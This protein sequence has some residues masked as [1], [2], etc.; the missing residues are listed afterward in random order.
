VRGACSGLHAAF[1]AAA[2]RRFQNAFTTRR[3]IFPFA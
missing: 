2:I 3:A 1:E